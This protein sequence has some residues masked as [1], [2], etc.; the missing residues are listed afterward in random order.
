MLNYRTCAFELY[1]TK[2]VS[3][4]TVFF[5]L[6]KKKWG[7][8][9]EAPTCSIEDG[10]LIAVFEQLFCGHEFDVDILIEG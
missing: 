10:A 9:P 7:F 1:V 2:R 8:A 3:F 4:V 5:G 6:K